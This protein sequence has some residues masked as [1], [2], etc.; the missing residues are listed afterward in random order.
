MEPAEV[1]T[2]LSQMPVGGRI[3][4]R[5][6]IDWRTAAVSKHGEEKTTL[7]VASASG[8]CYRIY[9]PLDSVVRQDGCIAVL[10]TEIA[11]RWRENMQQLD[12]RW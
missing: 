12:S 7:T 9:R 8:R 4:V 6:R 2:I 11:E 3:M 1:S 5:S 10:H